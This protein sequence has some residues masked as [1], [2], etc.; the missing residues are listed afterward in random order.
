MRERGHFVIL[1]VEKGG[2]LLLEARKKGF[3]VYEMHY[4]KP[5]ALFTLC[6]LFYILLKNQIDLVNTHSSLDSWMGGIAA[7]ILRRRVVRTRHLSTPIRKG[8]NSLIL[9][10]GLPDFVVTTS[11]AIIPMIC[12]QAR[13]S[14]THCRCIP[15]GVDPRLLKVDAQEVKKFREKLGLSSDDTLVGTACFVRSW[16]GIVD[17]LKAALLLKD[18]K[19]LK[20]V[21]VG[22]GY[23]NEY[24]PRAEEMGLKDTV[25]FTGHL[26]PPY[27]AIAA[28]DIFVLLSTAHEGISQATLQAAYLERPLI[29][30]TVGGLPEVCLEGVTGL[31]VPPFSPEKIAE[32]VVDLMGNPSLRSAMGQKGK[33]LVLEKFTLEKTLNDMEAVFISVHEKK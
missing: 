11:S 4:K 2:G 33:K 21:V 15:T 8:I 25:I 5:F 3:L 24:I 7:K 32:K 13:L 16:K 14:A 22:G 19:N 20:W 6:K 31:Q 29:T 1:A 9:Y 17:L 12:S 10:K 28:M 27:S 26:N 23:V 18:I 30:T